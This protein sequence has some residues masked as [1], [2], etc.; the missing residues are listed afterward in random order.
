MKV[1]PSRPCCFRGCLKS[2]KFGGAPLL[3]NW[4]TIQFHIRQNLLSFR[5]SLS[6]IHRMFVN[7]LHFHHVQSTKQVLRKMMM[8]LQYTWFFRL[9]YLALINDHHHQEQNC[10]ELL[11]I[12]QVLPISSKSASIS[13]LQISSITLEL[14]PNRCHI[15][16]CAKGNICPVW[17]RS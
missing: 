17:M 3:R 13:T 10:Q 1:L 12:I 11:T 9:I 5:T 14:A 8:L 4:T 7:S 16:R 6:G 2:H 15:H